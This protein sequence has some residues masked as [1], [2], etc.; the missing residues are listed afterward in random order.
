ITAIIKHDPPDDS[1]WVF[2]AENKNVTIQ[3]MEDETANKE[4]HE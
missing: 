3:S 2:D 1:H 4:V